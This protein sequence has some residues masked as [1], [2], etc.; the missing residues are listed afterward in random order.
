M[1]DEPF[2]GSDFEKA[3]KDF[4]DFGEQQFGKSQQGCFSGNGWAARCLRYHLQ[5]LTIDN[6]AAKNARALVDTGDLDVTKILEEMTINEFRLAVDLA[7]QSFSGDEMF[8]V[9]LFNNELIRAAYE[10]GKMR[11]LTEQFKRREK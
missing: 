1:F 9:T 10:L 6:K 3:I 11:A 2:S 7:L 5:Q 4:L 8:N